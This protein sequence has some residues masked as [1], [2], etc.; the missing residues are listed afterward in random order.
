MRK[1]RA[2]GALK[3]Q[4]LEAHRRSYRIGTIVVAAIVLILV[5]FLLALVQLFVEGLRLGISGS[6]VVGLTCFLTLLQLMVVEHHVRTGDD[7]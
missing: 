5:L 1:S 2:G 6:G 7:R 4:K 3:S